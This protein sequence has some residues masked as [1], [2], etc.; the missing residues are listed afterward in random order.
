MNGE[1][2]ILEPGQIEAP[3]G[4]IRHFIPPERDLF[5]RRAGRF[6]QLAPGHPLEEYLSFLANVADAQHAVLGQSSPPA[7]SDQ[8]D[9]ASCRE[10]GLPPLSVVTWRRAPD[11]REALA[12][13]LSQLQHAPLPPIVQ[14]TAAGLMQ[15]GD[16]GLEGMADLILAGDL[17]EVAPQ[18]LPFIAAALQVY[19]LNL[20]TCLTADAIGR[21]KQDGLCPV[22]GSLPGAG[23]IKPG[24]AEQG[25]RYLCCSL[26]ASQWHH[27]RLTCSCCAATQGINHYLLDG[28]SGAVKVECCDGCNSY[29]KLLYLEKDG[30][31]D[32]V[33][34]DLATLSL[35]MVM[36][37]KGMLRSAPNLLYHPGKSS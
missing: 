32:M 8:T 17:N 31:M 25:L 16:D 7:V 36:E 15:M 27:V 20:A 10:Q 37:R 12:A 21:P 30:E 11:W 4:E 5:A 34:D 9:Q 3:A 2:R 28:A 1:A 14:E 33:A 23:I 22:C 6:R 19:W 26:C 35:D 24:G 13:L 18:K 29:L